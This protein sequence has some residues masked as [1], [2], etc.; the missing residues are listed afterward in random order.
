MAA[1]VSEFYRFV[2]EKGLSRDF[3][4]RVTDISI[5]GGN[6]QQGELVLARAAS[7]P[8]RIIEDKIANYGGHEFHLG[9]RAVYSQS[10]GYPIE[11]YCDESSTLRNNL[12]QMSRTTFDVLPGAGAG[13]YGIDQNASITL[14]QLNKQFQGISTITL[15]GASIREIGDI[16]Y[17]IADG[18]GEIVS[19]TAT[20]AY[21]YYEMGA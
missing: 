18:T 1:T 3:L 2:A 20:F 15:K 6:I 10:D 7:V 13:N 11:F 21:Q 14:K 16:D 9:G 12:E 17:M 5:Q 8:G 4:F 19:F